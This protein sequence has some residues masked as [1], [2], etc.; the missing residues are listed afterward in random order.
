ME[1]IDIKRVDTAFTPCDAGSYGSRV[2][3]LAGEAAQKAAQDVRD[4]LAEFAA[5]RWEANPQDIVFKNHQVSV[6][7][8][9]EKSMPFDTLAKVACYSGSGAVIVGKGY[10]QYGIE[11]LDFDR[12]I[13]NCGTS[14]SF[15]SQLT[16]VDVDMETGFVHCTD[17]VIAHDCGRPLN[18]INVESQNQGAAMQ[19]LSQTMYEKFVMN[20]GKTLN[21]TLLD[22]KMP[23][24][25]DTPKIEVIDI[26]T[27]D[28]DGPYGAKEASEGAIVSAPPSIVSAI[29]DATGIWFK[30]QPV[31]PEKIAMALRDKKK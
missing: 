28:P 10:S 15:T 12:G 8:S 23:L 18:P 13:G 21:P 31:T 26:I 16:E 30:E 7:G 25:L 3:V 24:P 2:T 5:D 29:H 6:K 27:D 11:E 19:G 9:P 14:Y 20:Q 17:M 22:Y 1:D 4:Q